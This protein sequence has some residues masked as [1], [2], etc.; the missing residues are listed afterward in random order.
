MQDASV[1][2]WATDEV[3]VQQHG[4][5]CRMGIP[6]E[7]KDPVLLHAPTRKR[8][9]YCGA[10]RLR[11]GRFVF[12]RETGKCNGYSFFPFL[13]QLRPASRGTRRRVVVITDTAPS[14]HSR[15]HR[16][17]REKHAHR[18]VLDFLP[19]YSPEL[20]PIERVW[21]LTRRRCLHN[22]YFANLQDLLS[23]VESE[24]ANWTTR[25]DVLRRLCAIT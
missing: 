1:D 22:R 11:D 2:L 7:I 17:W 18:F 13:P 6:P 9:G 15:L 23:A 25:N 19:P 24:F 10:V 21:K 20:N 4:S 12:R 5:R 8:V 16:P 14:H 3:H